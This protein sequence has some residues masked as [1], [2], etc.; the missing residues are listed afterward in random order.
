MRGVRCT[1]KIKRKLAQFGFYLSLFL[2]F[3]VRPLLFLKLCVISL[4]RLG[5][6]TLFRS[7]TPAIRLAAQS[8]RLEVAEG[9]YN[10]DIMLFSCS[11]RQ[12]PPWT[13]SLF[14]LPIGAARHPVHLFRQGVRPE[15]P[16]DKKYTPTYC[17][18]EFERCP[19]SCGIT[20]KRCLN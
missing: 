5:S 13:F 16:L 15:W 4:R 2:L 7:P 20:E 1:K 18:T 14:Q 9:S 19:R 11:F 6:V 8:W 12:P 3:V 17:M 10:C